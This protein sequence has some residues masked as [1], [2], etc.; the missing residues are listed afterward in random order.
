MSLPSIRNQSFCLLFKR[1]AIEFLRTLFIQTSFYVGKFTN[2]VK[3][4]KQ[5]VCKK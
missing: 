4:K 3:S 5:R 1:N 2:L